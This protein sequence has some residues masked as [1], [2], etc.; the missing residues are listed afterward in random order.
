SRNL[1]AAR[2]ATGRGIRR[3]ELLSPVLAQTARAR[4]AVRLRRHRLSYTRSRVALRSTYEI[5]RPCRTTT[6][7]RDGDVAAQPV[8]R[9][10]RTRTGGTGANRGNEAGR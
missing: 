3:G 1:Q 8:S 9:P 5:T 2:R 4:S 10:V 7:R 6:A